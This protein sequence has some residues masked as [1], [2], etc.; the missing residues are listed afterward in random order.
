MSADP[1]SLSSPGSRTLALRAGRSR[2]WLTDLLLA[3]VYRYYTNR[4]RHEIQS[5]T[6]PAHVAVILDG[7]RRWASVTGLR[8]P[9]AGH[10]AGANKLDELLDWCARLGI[11]QVTVW[12]LSNEN[13]GP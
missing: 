6:L 10:R 3:P 7:N 9:W 8:E 11:G 4:L 2:R 1:G 13:L 12:A 5:S